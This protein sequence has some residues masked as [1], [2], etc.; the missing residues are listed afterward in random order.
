MFLLVAKGVEDYPSY[1]VNHYNERGT[2]HI[3][4]DQSVNP[5]PGIVVSLAHRVTKRPLDVI[6]RI[7]VPERRVRK[8]QADSKTRLSSLLH[9]SRAS[10]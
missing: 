9:R 8:G 4:S 10:L 1:V 5:W 3:K 6:P 7:A 2:S